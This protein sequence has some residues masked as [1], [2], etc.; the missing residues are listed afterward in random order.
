MTLRK[1]LME[2]QDLSVQEANEIIQEMKTRVH[3]EQETQKRYCMNT[4]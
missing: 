1:A 2:G 3:E 4:V